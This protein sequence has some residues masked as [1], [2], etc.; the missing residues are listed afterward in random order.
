M[1][2][3]YSVRSERRIAPRTD[4]SA[5]SEWG[6]AVPIEGVEGGDSANALTA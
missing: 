1:T 5:S 2:S 6:G 4:C 3:A